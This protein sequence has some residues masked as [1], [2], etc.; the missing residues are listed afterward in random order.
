[1]A[2][3]LDKLRTKKIALRIDETDEVELTIHSKEELAK[4]DTDTLIMV[5]GRLYDCELRLCLFSHSGLCIAHVFFL[6][7]FFFFF[8]I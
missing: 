2:S 7:F 8:L 3:K 5:C 4:F 1:V 6:F